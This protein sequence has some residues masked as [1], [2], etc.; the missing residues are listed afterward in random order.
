MGSGHSPPCLREGLSKRLI[1][2]AKSAFMDSC[3]PRVF[4]SK[5]TA[6]ID[7]HEVTMKGLKWG[8]QGGVKIGVVGPAMM[9]YLNDSDFCSETKV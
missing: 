3:M 8:G 9:R 1:A 6:K 5:A 4:A 2:G 7:H